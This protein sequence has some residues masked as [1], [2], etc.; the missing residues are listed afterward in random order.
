[1]CVWLKILRGDV[2]Q[3]NHFLMTIWETSGLDT[4]DPGIN[5]L[6]C[7]PPLL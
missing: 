1:M 3:D 6:Y 2:L 7:L 5:N 4:L